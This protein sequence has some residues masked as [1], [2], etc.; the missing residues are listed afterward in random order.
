MPYTCFHL[1]IQG[2]IVLLSVLF[3]IACFSATLGPVMWVLIS[4]IFPNRVRGLATSIAV[5][6]L[7]TANFILQYT[8]PIIKNAYSIAATFW[9]YA[10]V[11][12]LGVIF[13]K[14]FIP[15]TKGKT[16]EEIEASLL[17]P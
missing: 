11:C 4:E 16:L 2:V 13:I 14:L 17:K 10:A 5:L 3:A 7:W 8:F 1:Q 15:E 12:V 6:S 9:I